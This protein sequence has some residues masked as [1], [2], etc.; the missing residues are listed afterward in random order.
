MNS[1]AVP[2]ALVPLGVM[3]VTSTVPAAP[4]GDVAVTEVG[5]TTEYVVA[6]VAPK[7]TALA[8]LKPV[9]VMV[10]EVPPATG[11]AIGLTAVTVGLGS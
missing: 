3:T 1:S 11:P 10:T 7:S 4:A 8:A 6:P 2:V 9:P 5:E